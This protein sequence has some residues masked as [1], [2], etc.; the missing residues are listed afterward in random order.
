MDWGHLGTPGLPQMSPGTTTKVS[1]GV[2]PVLPK[3]LSILG[4]VAV[5][6]TTEIGKNDCEKKTLGKKKK[7]KGASLMTEAGYSPCFLIASVIFFASCLHQLPVEHTTDKYPLPF[8]FCLSS[9]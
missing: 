5:T 8:F 3:P 9:P 4:A 1:R 6:R 7:I 2:S